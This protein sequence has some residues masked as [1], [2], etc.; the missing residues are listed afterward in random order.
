MVKVGKR[1]S[2]RG[3][4]KIT[5]S[6]LCLLTMSVRKGIGPDEFAKTSWGQVTQSR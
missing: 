1:L 3:N 2:R 5:V 6:E 4:N